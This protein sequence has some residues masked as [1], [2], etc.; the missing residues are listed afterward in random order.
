MKGTSS[1]CYGWQ[2]R[3][4]QKC[5][6]PPRFSTRWNCW[7]SLPVDSAVPSRSLLGRGEL[8]RCSDRTCGL[9]KSQERDERTHTC[10]H[11][12]TTRRGQ[13]KARPNIVAFVVVPG[14]AA[15]A[16]GRHIQPQKTITTR[17]NGIL[18]FVVT[19]IWDWGAGGFFRNSSSSRR[20][21]RTRTRS[22]D[23][24]QLADESANG[25]SKYNGEVEWKWISEVTKIVKTHSARRQVQICRAKEE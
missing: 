13:K 17:L 12:L 14:A 11:T 9:S 21:E 19:N 25:R 3:E 16:S 15:I 20:G 5:C 8:E 24:L 2:K 18:F 10:T 1:F 4:L 23:A 6:W 7:C 22:N